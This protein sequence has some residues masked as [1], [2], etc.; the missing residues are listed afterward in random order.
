MSTAF[1]I[2]I[3]FTLIG[4]SSCGLIEPKYV[5]QSETVVA[6]SPCDQEALNL[7]TS[8]I[9]IAITQDCKNCHI[10][11]GIAG[12]S[13]FLADSDTQARSTLYAFTSGTAKTLVDKLDGTVSHSGGNKIS[14]MSES[15]ITAWVAK[16]AECANAANLRRPQR[17]GR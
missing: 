13:S 3:L 2:I 16:E 11:G 4:M 10:S 6:S 15:D 14:V 8:S 5:D 17:T 7:F 1:F 9:N 12:S